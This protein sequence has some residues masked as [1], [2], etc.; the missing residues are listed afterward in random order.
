M[1]GIV[2]ESVTFSRQFSNRYQKITLWWSFSR[3]IRH[4]FQSI[5]KSLIMNPATPTI[6]TSSGQNSSGSSTELRIPQSKIAHPAIT[7]AAPTVDSIHMQIILGRAAG[8]SATL[9]CGMEACGPA[10]YLIH[11]SRMSPWPSNK[12]EA[13]RMTSPAGKC[14]GNFAA[15]NQMTPVA[16]QISSNSTLSRKVIGCLSVA[17]AAGC[18]I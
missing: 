3:R 15:K 5:T 12:I 6:R 11:R 16:P 8:V 14:C 17:Q 18:A 13:A 9:P 1:A 10:T 2:S 7:P 4:V